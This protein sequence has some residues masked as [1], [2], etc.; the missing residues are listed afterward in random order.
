MLSL[1]Q[2]LVRTPL[3]T[4]PTA[5]TLQI[6]ISADVGRSAL[7]VCMARSLQLQ[8]GRSR[9]MRSQQRRLPVHLVC[10]RPQ[11]QLPLKDPA[12]FGRWHREPLVVLDVTAASEQCGQCLDEVAALQ[13]GAARFVPYHPWHPEQLPQIH[14]SPGSSPPVSAMHAEQLL[15]HKP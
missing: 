2:L 10:H 15:H 8:L 3:S 4:A 5:D 1:V 12:G 7:K 13:I 6:D 14:C 11:P 9:A